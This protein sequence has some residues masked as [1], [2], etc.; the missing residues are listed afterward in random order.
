[1]T[2]QSP[3]TTKNTT[4]FEENVLLFERDF[5][6]TSR[7]MPGSWHSPAFRSTGA[8]STGGRTGCGT[9]SALTM[10]FLLSDVFASWASFFSASCGT[11]RP[12]MSAL[13]T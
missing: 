1:M 10:R 12:P 9:D 3:A 8:F 13:G 4:R 2:R 5:R 7:S 11:N 6:A